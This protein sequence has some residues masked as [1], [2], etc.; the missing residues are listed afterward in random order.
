MRNIIKENG[1][2]FGGLNDRGIV[3]YDILDGFCWNR[4][5]G[6]TSD[7]PIHLRCFYTNTEVVLMEIE[8]I[9]TKYIEA[10]SQLTEEMK[11]NCAYHF[12]DGIEDA[13]AIL[14]SVMEVK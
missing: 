4:H 2:S 9:K 1:G 10:M 6:P 8:E 14:V 12:L 5:I 13:D 3:L 11:E 7:C